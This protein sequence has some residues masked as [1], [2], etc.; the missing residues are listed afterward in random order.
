MRERE[1]TGKLKY[2]SHLSD[3]FEERRFYHRKDG[4]LVKIKDDILSAVR[5]AIMMKRFARPVALGGK[6]PAKQPGGSVAKG[7]DFDLF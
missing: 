7:V 6:R 3:L 4:Q 1:A 2:A 5:V